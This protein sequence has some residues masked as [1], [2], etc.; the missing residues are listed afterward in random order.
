M[1]PFGAGAWGRR[2]SPA[3]PGRSP[4]PA[5]PQARVACA[6]LGL[7]CPAERAEGGGHFLKPRM[8]AD[9]AGKAVH[10][11]IDS[12]EAQTVP[13]GVGVEVGQRAGFTALAIVPDGKAEVVKLAV[14][15]GDHRGDGAESITAG[16]VFVGA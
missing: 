10:A 14:L 4:A 7:R 9:G 13:G 2:E 16:G 6:D 1:L 5:K 11:G 15:L 12:A 8:L 3:G